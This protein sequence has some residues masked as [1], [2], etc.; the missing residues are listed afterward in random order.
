MKKKIIVSGLL[1][2]ETTVR[3]K[4]FPINY[5]PIDFPFFGVNSN[6]SGVGCN[7]AKAMTTLGDEVELVSYLGKDDEAQ[8]VLNDLNNYGIRTDSI[9][10]C[11][12]NTPASVILFDPEGRRQIYCDLKDIQEKSVDPASMKASM[13]SADLAILCNINFNRELFKAVRSYDI[14]V[15][16]DVHVLS[17]IDDDYNRDF[18]QNSDILFLSDEKLSCPPEEFIRKLY[19]R[20]HNKV[21]VIGMG[22]KGALLL[23][24]EKDR[25]IEIPAFT[26]GNI[27]NTVGAGDALFSSFLHYYIKGLS[28][29]DALK[30]AVVFAGIK[31]GFNGASLGFADEKEL[32][33]HFAQEGYLHGNKKEFTDNKLQPCKKRGNR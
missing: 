12:K 7:I 16:T 19:D 27:V 24:S 32:E 18:M 23:D 14:P 28:A 13:E 4:G 11:L 15:A 25:L 3:V 30:R 29:E 8:R 33:K 10:R 26:A 9:S 17:N 31:I 1:N 20:Y 2:I 22:A 5:Y 6:I 21:I